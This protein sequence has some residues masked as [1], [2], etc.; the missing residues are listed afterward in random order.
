VSRTPCRL[1]LAVSRW[2]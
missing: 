2:P 1:S